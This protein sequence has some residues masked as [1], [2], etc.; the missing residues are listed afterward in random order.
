MLN[1]RHFLGA[2]AGAGLPLLCPPRGFSQTSPPPVRRWAAVQ[3][4]MDEYVKAG[5]I[6]GA[7]AALSYDGALVY[8][9][10]G[11]IALDSD[12]AADEN[13]IYRM[14]STTKVVTGIA[15]FRLIQDGK[16]RLDQPVADVVPEWKSLRVAIDPQKSLESRPAKTT[17]TMRHLLTHTSGLSYWIPA[18]GSGLLPTVYRERGITPGDT[19]YGI[20]ARPGY[21]PQVTSLPEM[22]AR[23][24][25]LPLAADPGTAY[26]YSIGYDV[27]GLIIER[28][29]GKSLE[30]Y[31]R[32]RIF[33]PLKM[34]SSG[35]QVPR[36]QAA[37]LTTNYEASADGLI[38]VDGA[39]SSVFLRPP[40]LV[41]GGGGLVSTARDFARFTGMLLG[42]G[43][44]DGVRVLRNDLARLACSNLLPKEVVSEFGFG[45]GMRITK[46]PKAG[47]SQSPGPVGTMSF[48][49]A[50]GCRWMVDPV[51]RGIMVFM[52]QRMP[53]PANGPLWNELH[54]A[55]DADLA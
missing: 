44:F 6:A 21:G 27:M 30:A 38:P 16:L 11:R 18:A 12:V 28:V 14:Y 4:V 51:R 7:V 41:A 34:T 42:Q 10:A 55:V 8:R 15:A 3:K 9:T 23:L 25:E 5:K 22:I 35:F 49:G 48:G 17:M 45:A 33:E 20:Q 52:T 47:S 32:R 46:I 31:F 2:L 29:S 19:Y 13:S 40:T 37:R 36:N 43:T 54:A 26:Q 50:A 53:G 39:E 1:R 24:A